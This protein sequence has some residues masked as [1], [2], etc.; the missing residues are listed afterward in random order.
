MPTLT[1]IRG[2]PGS[3]KTTLATQLAEQQWDNDKG[4]G[5]DLW[6][7]DQF[8][9]HTYGEGYK[10]DADMLKEAHQWCYLNTLK[11]LR[12]GIDVIVSNTFTRV[13]EM[14]NYVKLADII[15]DL[16][17]KIIEVKTQFK[18]VHGVPEEKITQMQ[19][20]WESVEG[21]VVGVEIEV[22]E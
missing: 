8:F 19:A 7:A 6:E 18:S 3:G 15:P 4:Y 16:T 5:P 2:L 11:S 1:L 22:V 9:E 13:W 20:R 10:F 17:I 12:D 14:A 21:K